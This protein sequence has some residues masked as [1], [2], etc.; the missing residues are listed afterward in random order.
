MEI[1]DRAAAIFPLP[2]TP[3]PKPQTLK[4]LTFNSTTL[5]KLLQQHK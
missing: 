3:H 5:A 2:E 4:S 1:V